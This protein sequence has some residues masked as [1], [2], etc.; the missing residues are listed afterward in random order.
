MSTLNPFPVVKYYGAEGK[1]LPGQQGL[2]Q[3][4]QAGQLASVAMNRNLFESALR[5]LLLE[6]S[7]HRVEVYEGTGAS[8]RL[9][10]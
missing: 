1:R 4:Q 5:E 10:K 8:W 2:Q 6:G 7:E 3:Q 9:T